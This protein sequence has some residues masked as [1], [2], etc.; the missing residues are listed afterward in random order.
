MRSLSEAP[1]RLRFGVT[2]QPDTPSLVGQPGPP[3]AP[4]PSQAAHRV[5]GGERGHSPGVAWDSRMGAWKTGLGASWMHF[6]VLLGTLRSHV[7]SQSLRAAVLQV[8][9][10]ED[11]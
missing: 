1:G 5:G 6:G 3:A 9:F 7:A 8:V 4:V 11:S 2:L 10:H